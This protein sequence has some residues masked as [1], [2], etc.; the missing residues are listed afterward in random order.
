[1]ETII[2]DSEN[3]RRKI[4]LPPPATDGPCCFYCG[5][6]LIW[7]HD[8]SCED[9]F[10]EYDGDHDATISI[11]QCAYCGRTYEIYD[12]LKSEREEDYKSYWHNGSDEAKS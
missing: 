11:Y 8:E 7:Q 10:A 4:I 12:P 6:Q 9:L 1:M 5:G 2:T 3:P